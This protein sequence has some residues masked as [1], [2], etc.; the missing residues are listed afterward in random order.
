M[1]SSKNNLI[2]KNTMMLYIRLSIV[3]IV[4]LYTGVIT[5]FSFF[6]G[7]LSSATSRFITYELG[8][9]NRIGLEKNFRT[10]F[11]IHLILAGIILI[12]AETIG[13]WFVNNKLIIPVE[14]LFAAN[15]IYQF[16]V[17]SC[18]VTIMQVMRHLYNMGDK[19][20]GPF[21]FYDAF[22]ETDNWYPQRYLAIDQGP[23]AVMIENY[24]TGLLWKLFMSH[25]DVQAGLTKLGFNTNKQDVRQQ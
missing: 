13:L 15:I 21:G 5:L 17:L 20:F 8:R 14:R 19:V 25:P 10:A 4:Y 16:S 23:I 24:R 7:A 18:V 3:M 9:E 1:S 6:N 11:T 2:A 12:L 22:S